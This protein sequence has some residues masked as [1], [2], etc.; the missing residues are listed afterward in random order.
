MNMSKKRCHSLF[1]ALVCVLLCILAFFTACGNSNGDDNKTTID[2][3]PIKPPSAYKDD[4]FERTYYALSDF[5]NPREFSLPDD[6]ECGMRFYRQVKIGDTTFYRN[7]YVQLD[8]AVPYTDEAYVNDGYSIGGLFYISHGMPLNE[9][10]SDKESF[11]FLF[12]MYTK[13]KVNTDESFISLLNENSQNDLFSFSVYNGVNQQ[14]RCHL[15]RLNLKQNGYT[16]NI[17]SD[18]DYFRVEEDGKNYVAA[19]DVKDFARLT[20]IMLR[21]AISH[22]Q[23]GLSGFTPEFIY[24][25]KPQSLNAANDEVQSLSISASIG[26]KTLELQDD[27]AIDFIKKICPTYAADESAI[28]S[29]YFSTAL[30]SSKYEDLS[31]AIKINMYVTVKQ[32]KDGEIYTIPL[33]LSERTYYLLPNNKLIVKM[34]LI[35][36]GYSI[37]NGCFYGDVTI[38]LEP[39]YDYETAKS[40]IMES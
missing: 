38:I 10:I 40:V 36:D 3:T 15:L 23:D 35:T 14:A 21:A 25:D 2:P 27:K 17:Y 22:E 20:K 13:C 5:P 28:P 19:V 37:E 26:E 39:S 8:N 30:N 7:D 9:V 34:N 31:D 11:D 18:V 12:G 33:N 29:Q 32:A 16:T 1:L 4:G 24:Y 6:A